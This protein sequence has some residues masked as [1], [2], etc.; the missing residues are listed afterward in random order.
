MSNHPVFLR[1]LGVS[2]LWGIN[3]VASAYLLRDFSPIFLSYSRLILTS[4]FLLSI[5]LINRKMHRPT[6]EEWIILL[7]V[8]LFGT[9]FNQFFY[10]IGLQ[11]S[12]AGNA[13]MILALSPIAT[14]FLARA[15][16][17]EAV[18][19]HKLIGAG[20]ALTGVVCI[21]LFGGATLGVSKGDLLLLVAMLALSASLLFIRKLSGSMPSYDITILATV[22]GTVLMTP[23]AV[24]EA[25]QGHMHVSQHASMWFILTLVAIFGQGLASFWWNQGISVVGASASSMFMNI[26]PF[27]AIVAAYLVLG[28]PIRTA[29]IIGGILIFTGVFISSRPKRNQDPKPLAGQL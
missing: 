9:L 19:L 12:T 22:I 18:T 5:A 24:W 17:G 26:P 13:S 4:L 29:Q 28:D 21:V 1:L 23:A 10:F 25:S 16:L 20:L 14:T 11:H 27:V 8:G 6:K 7:F 15:F 3:F 2:L